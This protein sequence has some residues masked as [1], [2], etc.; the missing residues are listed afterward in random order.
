MGAWI[1][2][3]TEAG[4]H[5]GGADGMGPVGKEMWDDGARKASVNI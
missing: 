4:S 3:R 2:V 1:G 5:V